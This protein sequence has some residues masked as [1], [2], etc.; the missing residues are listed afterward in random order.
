MG[1]LRV[2][3]KELREQEDDVNKHFPFPVGQLVDIYWKYHLQDGCAQVL[4][5]KF[6]SLV[7]HLTSES[8]KC[9]ETAG[10]NLPFVKKKLYSLY[11]SVE[12][13]L[14]I[15]KHEMAWKELT[16]CFAV[17]FYSRLVV[18]MIYL[19]DLQL[20]YSTPAWQDELA[21]FYSHQP[22]VMSAFLGYWVS[23]PETE[24]RFPSLQPHLRSDDG[25]ENV[26][27]TTSKSS[28]KWVSSARHLPRW[29]YAF[30]RSQKFVYPE[31]STL[32]KFHGDND[33][34]QGFFHSFTEDK[35]SLCKCGRVHLTGAACKCQDSK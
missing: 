23:H 15:H 2:A 7:P 22:C 19:E 29:D 12:E 16:A 5:R 35:L 14:A 28:E 8:N 20:H 13:L 34:I 31:L 26:Q 4:Y 27:K 24:K 11:K 9:W 18:S 3:L 17:V 21:N 6:R 10:N 30:N 33:L 25:W 1:A 32:V